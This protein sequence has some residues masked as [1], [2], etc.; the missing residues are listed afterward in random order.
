MLL[1]NKQLLKLSKAV[2]G[3]IFAIVAIKLV[4]M[5]SMIVV[6]GAVAQLIGR[7]GSTD[8]LN[9]VSSQILIAMA[10]TVV[11]LIGNLVL[12]EVKF[13]CAA[14]TRIRMRHKIYSKMLDLEMDYIVKAGTSNAVTASIDGVEA[15]EKYYSDYLPS[16]IYCFTAPFILFA[17]IYSYSSGSAWILLVLS[18]AV[19]PA[20]AVFKKVLQMLKGEFWDTLQKLNAMFLESL[21]GMTTL[22]LMNRD[23]DRAKMIEERTFGYYHVIVRTM[24]VTF[25]STILTQA[26]VY[27]GMLGSVFIVLNQCKS[28]GMTLAGAIFTVFLAFAFFRPVNELINSGHTALNGVAAAQN[29]FSFLGLEPSRMP[30][31][32]NLP[33]STGR[34]IEVKNVS[35]SYDKK[36]NIFDDASIHIDSNKT[37]ALVGP[38][39]C[40]KSTMVNLIMH[41]NDVD[42]GNIYLD[43]VDICSYTQ[44]ELRRRLALVPQ[45]TYIF[46]GTIEDNLKIVDP[47]VSMER[48][49]EVMKMVHLEDLLAQDGLATDVGEGGEKLSGGQKQKIGIARALITEADYLIFDEATSNVDA[50]S[51]DDIWDCIHGLSETKTLL[52]ISHRLS[53]VRN[54]D[55]IYVLKGNKIEES[56]THDDLIAKGGFYATLV[57]EQ[58]ILENYGRRV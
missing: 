42:K 1:I 54:A 46:S 6:F 9:N 52:I 20:N 26:F 50:D 56:G 47:S 36:V 7:I 30:A 44:D 38:S 8:A 10:G 24:K 48:M 35:F 14:K 43:G 57:S 39:G 18:I 49:T 17:R 12:G 19:L 4:V 13:R 34:G 51:E 28:G 41:F 45:N 27:G 5:I 29:I 55:T 33:E 21:E 23:N 2:A 15:L 40:G 3:W 25:Y 11:G 53:T 32:K 22:K 16:L 58:E 37:V 31:D